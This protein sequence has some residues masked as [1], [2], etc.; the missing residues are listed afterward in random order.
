MLLGP[1]LRSPRR[2]YL[3]KNAGS[4]YHLVLP[5]TILGGTFTGMLM[6]EFSVGGNWQ[7]WISPLARVLVAR[8]AKARTS[9]G[10][11]GDSPW[12][13]LFDPSFPSSVPRSPPAR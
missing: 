11:D 1:C 5:D 9:Q 13:V 2:W 3:G 10:R 7:N 12:E 4:S 6:T 8:G